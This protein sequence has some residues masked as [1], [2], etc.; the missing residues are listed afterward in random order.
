MIRTPWV[1]LS[2]VSSVD[3]TS[4]IVKPLSGAR[5]EKMMNEVDAHRERSIS[6]EGAR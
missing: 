4:V 3:P 6:E 5:P 2:V 1:A